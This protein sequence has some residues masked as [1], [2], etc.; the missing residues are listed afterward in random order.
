[1]GP[2]N[3]LDISK[4]TKS[5]SVPKL[6]ADGGNW[7][8]YQE[9]VMNFLKSKGLWHHVRGLVLELDEPVLNEGELYTKG[10]E[11]DIDATPLTKEQIKELNNKIDNFIQKEASVKEVLYWTV[12]RSTF[13]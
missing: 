3:T 10:T 5:L 1:M 9:H 11:D 8:F 7:P 2:D 12:D 13:L 6:C 4:N